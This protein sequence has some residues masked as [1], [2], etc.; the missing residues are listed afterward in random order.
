M[1]R[2]PSGQ[3]PIDREE[4]LRQLGKRWGSRYTLVLSTELELF[5]YIGSPQPTE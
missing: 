1:A 3:V 2:R 4:G 5:K